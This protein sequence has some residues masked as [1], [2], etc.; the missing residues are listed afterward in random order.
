PAPLLSVSPAEVVAQVPFDAA[1]GDLRVVAATTSSAPRAVAI[2]SA[3]PAI[4]A[5]QRSGSVLV[6]YATGLG[7]VRPDVKAGDAA[8]MSPLSQTVMTP[9]VSVGG[10]PA[11]VFFSG[12]VPG[13]VALYQVNV[14][15]P[16]SAASGSV[17]V[18]LEIGGRRASVIVNLDAP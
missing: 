1:A 5:A 18:T 12:L 16:D 7:G 11:A 3:A 15:L 8:P 14:T 17:T 13:L 4:V 10:R 9:T 2:D 6:L